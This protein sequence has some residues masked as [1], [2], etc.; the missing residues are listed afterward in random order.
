MRTRKKNIS[1]K[2]LVKRALKNRPKCGPAKGYKYLESLKPGSMFRTQ[3]GMKGVLIDCDANAKV[4]IMD[5]NVHSDDKNYYLGK[6][7]IA[8]K[9]EVKEL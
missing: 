8:A 5:V 7:I 6:H 9:T 1:T 4:I 2:L 3:S